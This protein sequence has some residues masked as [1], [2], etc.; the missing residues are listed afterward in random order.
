MSRLNRG[1]DPCK[2][3]RERPSIAGAQ[4]PL[5]LIGHAGGLG[6]VMVRGAGL[7]VS[8]SEL[9]F[10]PAAAASEGPMRQDGGLSEGVSTGT[11]GV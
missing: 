3:V 11:R 4:R 6:R 1:P 7:E 9:A 8:R 2:G 5:G 10:R